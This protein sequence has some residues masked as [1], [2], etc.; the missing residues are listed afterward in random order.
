M[1]AA[2][3]R[4]GLITGCA[5]LVGL[6]VGLFGWVGLAE[7]GGV[8]VV[9]AILLGEDW[10]TPKPADPPARRERPRT[11]SQGRPV[12]FDRISG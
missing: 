6:L 9:L 8:A 12:D 4:L 11:D 7:I 2:F 5:A 3:Y 10:D 1:I